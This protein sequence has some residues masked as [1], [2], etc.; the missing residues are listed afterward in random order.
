MAPGALTLAAA[1]G[2]GFLLSA[3]V[4]PVSLLSM[5]RA[6][7]GLP[8]AAFATGAGVATCDVA[9]AAAGAAGL[10]ALAPSIEAVRA[11]LLILAGLILLAAAA[12]GFRRPPVEGVPAPAPRSGAARAARL[13]ACWLEG[14][15][16]TAANPLNAAAVAG[17]SSG[18]LARPGSWAA[19]AALAAFAIGC[20][21]W[22]AGLALGLHRLRA[23]AG[24][25]LL[26]SLDRGVSI[27]LALAGAAALAFGVAAL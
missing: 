6:L 7:A 25:R 3:P 17:A 16:L 5:R 10:S 13:G 26:A 15:L 2:L 20:F 9:V 19:P 12:A 22:W 24:A 23:R 27:A 11:P 8:L 14:L 4:G 21:A 1:A 18:F